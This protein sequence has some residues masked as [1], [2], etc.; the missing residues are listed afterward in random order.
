[1][2]ANKPNN[3]KMALLFAALAALTIWV[4]WLL[5]TT[6]LPDYTASSLTTT[7]E[8]TSAVVSTGTASPAIVTKQ[9]PVVA[10]NQMVE[11]KEPQQTQDV[12]QQ[13]TELPQTIAEP[14]EMAA[15]IAPEP[16]VKSEIT[17]VIPEPVVAEEK[18]FVEPTEIIE[19]EPVKIDKSDS[20]IKNQISELSVSSR[21]LTLFV[22]EQLVDN[23]VV[24]V[25]SAQKG[26]LHQQFSPLVAPS[27]KYQTKVTQDYPITYTVDTRSYARYTPY[28]QLLTALPVSQSVALYQELLPEIAK[29]YRSL[30]YDDDKF[31][32]SLLALLQDLID[33]PVPTGAPEL[34]AP[35]AMFEYKDQALEQLLPVQKLLIRMGPDNQ[36]KVQQKLQQFLTELEQVVTE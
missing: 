30:G 17:T 25:D 2:T 21:L 10:E 19:P 28:Q 20:W 11:S 22:N 4:L 27:G 15:V 7:E 14:A 1:M 24:F 3:K 36:Q 16:Q 6:E 8:S 9:E 32:L 5:F 31:H 29:S 35:S 18:P 34:H 26:Q 23:L 12:E 33:T 13:P